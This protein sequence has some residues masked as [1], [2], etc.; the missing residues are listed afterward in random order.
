MDKK[1]REQAI[2]DLQAV[3]IRPSEPRICIYEFL[4]AN[5]IHPGA[6]EIHKLLQPDHP[7]L[8][9]TTVYNTLK[10][11]ADHKLV[12]VLT[13]ESGELRYD[14]NMDFHA[15]FKCRTCG[16]VHD[17]FIEQPQITIDPRYQVEGMCLDFYG[18]CPRCIRK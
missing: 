4:L 5:R 7:T 10:L 14:I 16:M 11:F 8:S 1:L 17:L 6:E 2:A 13:I 15:H 3:S 9:L 12:Q 18:H